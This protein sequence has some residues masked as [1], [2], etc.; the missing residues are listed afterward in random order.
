MSLCTSE[1][2]AEQCC[3][4]VQRVHQAQSRRT[5]EACE[6]AR[7]RTEE[8][9]QQEVSLRKCKAVKGH[10]VRSRALASEGLR[11]MS[12]I[13]APEDFG[14]VQERW[15]SAQTAS[16]TRQT[17]LLM[18]FA[19]GR[20]RHP[21]RSSASAAANAG[22][23]GHDSEDAMDDVAPCAEVLR[24][25]EEEDDEAMEEVAGLVGAADVASMA[26]VA[27]EG[28]QA[29]EARRGGAGRGPGVVAGGAAQALKKLKVEPKEAAEC[30]AK[31]SLYEC[32]ASEVEKM[33][34]T[35]LSFHEESR[36]TM[37]PAVAGDLDK[38][39]RGIDS[40][41]AMGI[42][43]GQRE[44]FV[45]HMMRQADRN[46][47]LMASILDSF[48]KKLE[49]LASSSQA[50]CP[51]CLEDFSELGGVRA[52][53][54]LSCCHKVCKECWGNWSTV[55]HGRPFCPLCR[56]DEFLGE[57]ATRAASR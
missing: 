1:K 11:Q 56:H 42:Q 57:V 5:P 36:P 54:T 7:R 38:Q 28:L 9:R 13:S 55:M 20:D 47:A 21:S 32:Y 16:E 34:N 22:H 44:W 10:T 15:R 23:G 41:E 50:E 4:W 24:C 51:I 30:A 52:P 18:S 46:N 33:R 26:A 53:E 49:L 3:E 43:D 8:M 39:V 35:L 29:G 19:G 27:D 14:A 17:K 25:A 31:F 37:P 2:S 12:A 48:E 45:F 6:K 40:E